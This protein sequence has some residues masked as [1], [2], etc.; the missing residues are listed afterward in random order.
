MRLH[1][2]PP[3]NLAPGPSWPFRSP[4]CFREWHHKYCL[5]NQFRSCRVLIYRVVVVE[6]VA[7]V[8]TSRWAL[9]PILYFFKYKN[10]LIALRHCPFPFE[11]VLTTPPRARWQ[12]RVNVHCLNS[13]E[14]RWCVM[15]SL[16]SG[17]AYLLLL[18]FYQRIPSFSTTLFLLGFPVAIALIPSLAWPPYLLFLLLKHNQSSDHGSKL[19]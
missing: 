6:Q 9:F 5:A 7:D 15:V 13:C 1:D 19:I 8:N 16:C 10:L 11:D 17:S 3:A 14:V 18:T 4:I 12:I 2:T